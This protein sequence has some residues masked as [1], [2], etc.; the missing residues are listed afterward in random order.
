[1]AEKTKEATSLVAQAKTI[2]AKTGAKGISAFDLATQ[3][4]LVNKD[5]K[6]VDRSAALKKVRTLARKAIGGK[7]ATKRE[8]RAAIYV[9]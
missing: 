2:I 8:G 7:P 1:M 9:V 5:M 3:M 4:K 6:P